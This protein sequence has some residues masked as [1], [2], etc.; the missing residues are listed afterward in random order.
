VLVGI[1]Q[2]HYLPWLRYIEKIAAVDIFIVLDNIQYNKNGWQ[3][4][5]KIKTSSGPLLLT[6]PV[7]EQVA[8]SLQDVRIRTDV[9]WRKKHM[10]SIE[11]AYS[12]APYFEAHYPFLR[13]TYAQEWHMLND[14]NRHMLTYFL[15]S[16]GI[17]T[18]VVYASDLAAPGV[19]TDRLIQLIHAIGGDAYYS[20]AFAADTYLD[21]DAMARAG[22][23]LTLQ[24]W[25]SPPYPQLHGAYVPDLSILDLVLNCGSQSLALLRKG[26]T[27]FPTAALP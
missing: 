13:D 15:E 14:L 5:N 21:A 10:R 25:V 12:K 26:T 19:A 11:Q 4:R 3:N 24:H 8:Q 18:P 20:G 16:L 6:V 23:T 22:I 2:L 1:H 9:P 27:W 7:L 17:T